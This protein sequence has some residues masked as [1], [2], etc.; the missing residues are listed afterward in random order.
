MGSLLPLAKTASFRFCKWLFTRRPK[1]KKHRKKIK[2]VFYPRPFIFMT[3]IVAIETLWR[4]TRLRC[5]LNRLKYH[6]ARCSVKRMSL[7]LSTTVASGSVYRCVVSVKVNSIS[8]NF[9][10]IYFGTPIIV[11]VLILRGLT[12]PIENDHA[13]NFVQRLAVLHF[14]CA[15]VFCSFM[16]VSPLYLCRVLRCCEDVCYFILPPVVSS[17][18]SAAL[19]TLSSW[20]SRCVSV[21]TTC[22]S[23]YT[24]IVDQPRSLRCFVQRAVCGLFTR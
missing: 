15:N 4:W 16:R 22:Q 19:C 13:C 23:L 1:K 12:V 18:T 11:P 2:R 8:V 6:L 20:Y 3:H 17:N 5:N 14:S 24:L 10:H 21:V 7:W 9:V